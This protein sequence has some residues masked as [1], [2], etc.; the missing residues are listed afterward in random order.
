[1]VFEILISR[2]F[3]LRSIR[4]TMMFGFCYS[5]SIPDPLSRFL[6]DIVT[7]LPSE[8]NEY[9]VLSV[10][11][12]TLLSSSVSSLPVLLS[13]SVGAGRGGPFRDSTPIFASS[14]VKRV[15]VG[16]HERISLLTFCV[17]SLEGTGFRRGWLRSRWELRKTGISQLKSPVWP[18][19]CRTRLNENKRTGSSDMI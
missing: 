18:A 7:G 4:S 16:M 12:V 9:V 1:M 5:R 11:C 13:V 10:W 19:G 14:E 6:V 2:L 15:V 8:G 17:V 3:H